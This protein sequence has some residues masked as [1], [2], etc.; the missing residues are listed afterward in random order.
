[1]RKIEEVI[2]WIGILAFF[3]WYIPTSYMN[4]FSCDDYWFGSY[5]HDIGFWKTQAQF[6]NN[7]EG[8]YTHTFLASI[9]HIIPGCKAPFL[10]NFISLSFLIYSVYIFVRTFIK[11]DKKNS[12]IV[13]LYLTVLLFIATSGGAEVRFW[14]CA[15]FTYLPELALVLLFLSRYHLL[16]NGRNKPIDWLVIFALTIGI[17]GSK[18]T[19]IAFSFICILIH[20][21]ICRRKID[22]VM[23]IAYGMLTILTMVNVLAP[24]NLV[25]LTDEHMHNAD[26]I[27][28]FT[29]LDNT[30]YRLKM[31]FSVIFYAF[32]LIP[33]SAKYLGEVKLKKRTLWCMTLGIIAGFL[34]ETI[35]MHV[36]FGDPGPKRIF[37]TYDLV[38]L[39][40]V[41][42]ILGMAINKLN[43]LY[44]SILSIIVGILFILVNIPFINQVNQS[45]EYSKLS[46]AR[47]RIVTDAIEGDVIYLPKLPNSYLILSYFSN[48]VEWIE[49]VYL[50]YFNKHNKVVILYDNGTSNE[51]VPEL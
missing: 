14:V 31:Q 35:I 27:S 6:Y 17:A 48:E 30:I 1:M 42:M 4:V 40:F 50:P 33:I 8:S 9:P 10:C 25:R 51:S 7:W 24:G 20:D 47:D 44:R 11:I 34:I 15:N 43:T 49:N 26:V 12:L 13:S 5:I 16:Y 46:Q 29:L 2:I 22:K 38:I 18:L 36:C 45:I 19:F 28:N 3:C 23:I 39:F 37:F 41:S 32:L 21:L